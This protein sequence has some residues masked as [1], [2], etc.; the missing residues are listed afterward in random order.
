MAALLYASELSL[1]DALTC[2]S[3]E[4]KKIIIK[5]SDDIKTS[6]KLLRSL[7]PTA[8]KAIPI[9]VQGKIKKISTLLESIVN[10]SR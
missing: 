10:A 7:S 5:V 6:I 2:S 3:A 9:N 1:G 8:K 4:K